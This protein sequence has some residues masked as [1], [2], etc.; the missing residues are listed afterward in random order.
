MRSDMISVSMVVLNDAICVLL[1]WLRH[2]GSRIR[3]LV[4]CPV[5]SVWVDIHQLF[6]FCY[7]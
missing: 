6:L 3:R 2:R 5:V 1:A 4:L 7:E